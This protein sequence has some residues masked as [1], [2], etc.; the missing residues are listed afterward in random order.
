L[1]GKPEGSKPFGRP[2]CRW[3]VNIK[4]HLKEIR[5]KVMDLILLVQE[6]WPVAS[7]WEHSN[8]PS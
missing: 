4:I 5:E 6:G 8:E 1:S 2:R 3:K 7:S